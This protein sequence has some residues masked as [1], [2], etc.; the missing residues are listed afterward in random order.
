MMMT[1]PLYLD[2]ARERD[3]EIIFHTAYNETY[4]FESPS[5]IIGRLH[6]LVPILL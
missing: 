1:E 4:F 2:Y 6:N 5:D 3:G